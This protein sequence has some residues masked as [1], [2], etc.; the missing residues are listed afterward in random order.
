MLQHWDGFR[1][2]DDPTTIRTGHLFCSRSY[3]YPK[4]MGYRLQGESMLNLFIRSIPYHRKND[5][6]R[7]TVDYQV[8]SYGSGENLLFYWWGVCLNSG[9]ISYAFSNS[10]R[11]SASFPF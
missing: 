10:A 3:F 6:H 5:S 8:G 1:L 7:R 4:T 11:D 9:A 2:A